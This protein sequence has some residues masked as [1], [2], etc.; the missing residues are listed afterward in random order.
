M[1]KLYSGPESLTVG[2]GIALA[3]P[4]TQSSAATVWGSVPVKRSAGGNINRAAGSQ[5]NGA[6]R[7]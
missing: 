2:N 5:G 1:E 7:R 4:T 3:S 6:S